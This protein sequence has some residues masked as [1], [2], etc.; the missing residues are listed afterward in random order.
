M[1]KL[2]LHT[3]SGNTFPQSSKCRKTGSQTQSV[4][5]YKRN[6][7]VNWAIVAK[8]NKNKISTLQ[9][10]INIFIPYKHKNTIQITKPPIQQH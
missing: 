8:N 7:V 10:I 4:K 5:S 9:P 6:S 2:L 3:A 1:E